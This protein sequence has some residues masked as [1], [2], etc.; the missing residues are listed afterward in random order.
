MSMRG[1]M[2]LYHRYTAAT[3]H[4]EL[5]QLPVRQKG[6]MNE[7]LGVKYVSTVSRWMDGGD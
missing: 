5:F 1:L 3:S 7:A 2:I 4:R 6:W